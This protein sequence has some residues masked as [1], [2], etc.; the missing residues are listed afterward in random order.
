MTPPLE[1]VGG[2]KHTAWPQESDLAV[3]KCELSA[4][5]G[6]PVAH[7]GRAKANFWT[8]RRDTAVLMSLAL[9]A[10]LVAALLAVSLPASARTFEQQSPVSPVQQPTATLQASPAAAPEAAPPQ[11]STSATKP[12]IPVW[13]LAAIM[14]VIGVI[15][16]VVGL[17]R[18]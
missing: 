8:T 17:R 2:S 15:A 10:L 12:P 11:A 4:R 16:L 13:G 1:V 18:R 9:V 6:L 5:R 3:K 14:G 7:S